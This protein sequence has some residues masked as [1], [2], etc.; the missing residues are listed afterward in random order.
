MAYIK[1]DD[2]TVAEVGT[3]EVRTVYG[4]TELAKRKAQLEAELAKINALTA[5]LNKVA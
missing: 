4:S 1:I 2:T 5:E 3:V